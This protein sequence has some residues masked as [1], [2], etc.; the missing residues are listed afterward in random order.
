MKEMKYLAECKREVLDTSYCLGFL[1]YILNLGTYPT[2]YIK[3]PRNHR[4][5]RK[6]L[7]EIYDE[8][9]INVH[10]GITYSENELWISNT[11]KI[12]GHFIGWD[13]AHC[14]DYMGFEERLPLQLRSGGK[15]WTTKEIFKE[16]KEVCYQLQNAKEESIY[17]QYTQ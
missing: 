11:Q 9:D 1:Y 16:I 3:I 8:I 2:A 17:E 14:G 10:G 15:K 13:Y 7:A 5:Y 6:T 12:E 4:L